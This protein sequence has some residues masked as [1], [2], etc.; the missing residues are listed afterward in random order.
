M[1]T[2]L[3]INTSCKSL[4]IAKIVVITSIAIKISAVVPILT[5]GGVLK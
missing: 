1:Y 4:A 2:T 3:S 5:K